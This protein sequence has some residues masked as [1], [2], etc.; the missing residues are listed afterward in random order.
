MGHINTQRL[1]T[2]ENL[3]RYLTINEL[4]LAA[5][6]AHLHIFVPLMAPLEHILTKVENTAA[7]GWSCRGSIRY[8]M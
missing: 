7:E 2:N 5:Y 3:A 6:V 1:T 4:E 8:A